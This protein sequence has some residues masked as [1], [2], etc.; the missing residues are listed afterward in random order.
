[1]PAAR[2]EPDSRCRRSSASISFLFCRLAGIKSIVAPRGFRRHI[3]RAHVVRDGL[4]VALVRVAPA[5]AASRRKDEPVAGHEGHAGRFF[6]LTFAAVRADERCVVDS[7]GLASVQTPGWVLGTLAIDISNAVL[8]R[9]IGEIDSKP[10]AMIAGTAGIRT[11]GKALDEKRILNLLQLDRGATH[12]ALTDRYRSGF[13]VLVR[14]STPSAAENVHQQE[15]P[16]VRPIATDRTSPHVTFMRGRNLFRQHRRQC[17]EDGVDDGRQR[18]AP[19]S[20]RRRRFGIE[21]F[22]RWQNELQWTETTFIDRRMRL[23][24]TFER[25]ARGRKTTGIA[26]IGGSRHLIVHLRKVDDGAI[27][28]DRHLDFDSQRRV[29]GAAV[30]IEKTL[31]LVDAVR[32]ST[33]E[34]ARLLFG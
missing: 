32:N 16:A 26:G 28:I 6:K 20:K 22:A 19:E 33:D 13:A 15:A 8:Q 30:I 31:R 25:Y 1:M 3:T 4:P 27:A 2:I 11:Q 24:E 34:G 7:A 9:A 5:A 17:L 29:E 18:D 23:G 14:T 10:A 12:I 21:D